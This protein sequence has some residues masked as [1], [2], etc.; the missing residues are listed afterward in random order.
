MA[1]TEE[2]K[3]AIDLEGKNI[4]V[5]AGAGSGKTAVLT[6]RVLRKLQ[7][8][9]SI[10]NLLILTFTNAAAHEMK[11]RIRNGI[12]KDPSLEEQ[13]KY[14][15]GASIMTF[16][17]YSLSLVKKYHTR[18]NIAKDIEVCDEVILTLEKQRILEEI[19]DKY[20]LK[21]TKSFEKLI[22][23]FCLKDDQNIKNVLLSIYRKIELKY[24]KTEFLENY[25]SSMN[26]DKI[27]SFIEEYIEFLFQIRDEIKDFIVSLNDYFDGDFVSKM[28]DNFKGLL[29]AKN[30]SELVEGLSFESLRV[31]SGS[32][33]E[34]KK[35]KAI[36]FQRAKDLASF[37]TY[38]SI[39]E[40]REEIL[41]TMD[42][43]EVI[44]EILKEFNYKLTEYK[45]K[46]ELFTFT[47]IS[48][49]AIQVVKE[50]PDILEELQNHYQ[51]IMVDE[52]QD[53]SDTQEAF[54][55]LIS[56]NNV[57][58][59]GDI[60]QS[61]YRF[62]NANPDIFKNKY[63]S[64][65]DGVLGEKI[66][67]VKNFRSRGEVLDNINLL[68]THFMDDTYGGANYRETHQMVFGNEMYLKEGY[69]KENHQMEVFT[70][71]KEQLGR[72]TSSEEEAFL[73]AEDI[74]K[75]VENHY[76]I[77]DKDLGILR[78][79]EYKDFVILLDRGRDFLLYKKIFEYYHIPL[80]VLQD[81]SIK[82]ED[83]IFCIKN[84]LRLLV[85]LKKK[86]YESDFKYSFVS[87]SRSFL[88][89]TDDSKIYEF[90]QKNTIL[91]SDLV[92]KCMPLIE[93][94]DSISLSQFFLKVLKEFQYEEKLLTIGNV[95]YYEA[96]LE[97]LYRLCQNYEKTG[98]TI[99]Q[100][101]SFLEDVF[102]KD[103][104][105]SFNISLEESN[106]CRIMTIHKSK[107]LEFPICYYPGL[108][109][110]FNMSD[111]KER[112]LYDNTYGIILPKVEESY[113]DT[114]LKTLLKNK[115]KKEEISE[116]IRLF[117]V[118]LTRAKEKMIFVIPKQEEEEE[119]R[120]MVPDY[121]RDTY[122]SFLS[123]LKSVYSLLLPY[124]VEK[125]IVG[126]KDY[127]KG[128]QNTILEGNLKEKIVVHEI[129]IPT[130]IVEEKH[131]SKRKDIY[132]KEELNLMKV[133]SQIHEVL[134]EINFQKY[135][136]SSY[137]LDSFSKQKI[138]SFLESDFLKD[139]LNYPMYKEL[140][141]VFEDT[142]GII[143]L[144]I[145]GKDEYFVIDY[146]LK[147]IE[148]EAYQKQLKGYQKF[149]EEK[150]GKKV[151]CYLY[152]LFDEK[153]QE[154]L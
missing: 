70:Y 101:I 151:S 108:S 23:D 56:R 9:I 152:S 74:K 45:K 107:G 94:M 15:D 36:I 27:N 43:V 138:L 149:V 88:Y 69:T 29:Q 125:D 42:H 124:I 73:I 140:E 91:E 66:D 145:E 93:D 126:N 8:G 147:N 18:L 54:I 77:F 63:D 44:V 103:L 39:D 64:Y 127:L 61:I 154:V 82:R 49:L 153:Y 95:S 50:N 31:P 133:G 115:T 78:D 11:E 96:R 41:S 123:I 30:Y 16:D 112:I 35:L 80:T 40:M 33:E 136:L 55:S 34:G 105:L 122:H 3:K 51:E 10:Q 111:L 131:F 130:E 143:D 90:V 144:L 76:P 37:C 128:I 129:E 13:L 38:S 68:F 20:Y 67:L 84:L 46:E 21:P 146:K 102:E 100:F 86:D 1:W 97:Y 135:D 141:F 114:I 65:S 47:D 75:K 104:D 85:C 48:S 142:H 119:V 81:E 139:K 32:S 137:D 110:H 109:V 118:A 79:A 106:S 116:R 2:Q 7:E 150:T 87:V 12:R 121:E 6:A 5:S 25:M 89:P 52:Y 53:T 17:A 19:L 99:Y 28:E 71:D 4:L 92:K 117:Y 57:Y 132:S 58:M 59:V 83:D 98:K 148:D 62:R 14:I 22:H 72:L 60:K 120:D 134:E 26:Q 24:D 113:K